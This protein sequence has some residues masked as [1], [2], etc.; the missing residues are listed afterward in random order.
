MGN[1]A[2]PAFIGMRLESIVTAAIT[3]ARVNRIGRRT[4]PP[5]SPTL[6]ADRLRGTSA[7]RPVA[8]VSRWIWG[9]IKLRGINGGLTPP[10]RRRERSTVGAAEGRIG[11]ALGG[12]TRPGRVLP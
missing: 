8:I 5:R 3:R 9:S 2:E 11:S 1:A 6:G 10:G 7:E 4:R 12:S